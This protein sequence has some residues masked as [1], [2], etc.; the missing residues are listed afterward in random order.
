MSGH[1]D[2]LTGVTVLHPYRRNPDGSFRRCGFRR[3]EA[4]EYRLT[5]CTAADSQ[6]GVSPPATGVI[7]ES[8]KCPANAQESTGLGREGAR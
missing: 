7:C 3:F 4:L 1:H 2:G 6:V 8:F 5:A